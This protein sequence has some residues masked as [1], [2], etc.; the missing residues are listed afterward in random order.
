MLFRPLSS[1]ARSGD[2][3][4]QALGKCISESQC[5][6]RKLSLEFLN[7]GLVGYDNLDVSGKLNVLNFLCDETLNTE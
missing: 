4:L 3:W 5:C 7:N 6:L 2:A 1:S